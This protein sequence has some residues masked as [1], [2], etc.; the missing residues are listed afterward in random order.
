MTNRAL[1]SISILTLTMIS[2]LTL[3]H[4]RG[5]KP[6]APSP[7]AKKAVDAFEGHWVLDG[8]VAMPGAAPAKA[9]L[10]MDCKKTAGGKAVACTFSGPFEGSALVAYDFYSK[11]VHFMAVTSDDE[12]HDHKCQWQG[13]QK[14]VCDPLK[15]GMSGMAITEELEFSSAPKKLALK[16]IVTMPD[17]GKGNCEFKSKG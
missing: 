3:A 2:T 10:K 11:A 9:V 4:A 15:A 14:L 16:A 5:E 13:D 7:E 8:T 1:V 12:V 17:G 6:P